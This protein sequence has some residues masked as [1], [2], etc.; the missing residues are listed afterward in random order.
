MSSAAPA[1]HPLRAVLAQRP[2]T[3]FLTARF[4]GSLAA[5]MQTVA[6]GVQVYELTHDPLDLGLVGLSQFAPFLLFVLLA[7][8]AADRLSRKRIVFACFVLQLGCSAALA[9]LTHAGLAHT[10]PVFSVMAVLGSAR[11]MMAPA[12]QAL[13]PNLVPQALFGRAVGINSGLWQV[14]TIAGPAVGGALYAAAG[15]GGVYG[16]AAALNAVAVLATAAIAAPAQPAPT[17]PTSWH[18]LLEGLRFVWR[19]HGVLGAISLDLFAVLFGGATA[20]LP[21]YATDVLGVGVTGLGWLRAAPGI[22]AALMAAALAARPISRRAGRAMFAGVAVFGVATVVFGLSRSY[23]LSLVA[24]AA[25]GAADMV[26]VFVRHLLVQLETPD[27]MRGRV[28]A[29]SWLFIGASNELGEFESGITAAWWGLVPAV[30]VGGAATLAV[31]ALWARLFPELRR[32]DRFPG[33]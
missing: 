13:M 21:A 27:A 2:F 19:R 4:A 10:W 22:G 11:A 3:R 29:V 16:A 5:Q 20:L 30:V 31:A 28:G 14:A 18:T 17:A 33:A 8:H 9:G 26:S 32:L 23:W 15:P 1:V 6:V 7:G 24:L 25:L 12:S